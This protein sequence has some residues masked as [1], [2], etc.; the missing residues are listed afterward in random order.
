[1]SRARRSDGDVTK[2]KILEAAGQLIAQNGFAQ[3]SNKAIAQAAKVDLAAI[4]YHF[5]GRDG[6]YKAV[7][8]EAHS[9]YIDEQYLINLVESILPPEEKLENF[10]GTFIE[11]IKYKNQWHSKVFIREIV[12]SSPHLYNFMQ[13]DGNR[14]FRL[15]CKIISQVSG[16]DE[17]NPAL[18]P[19]ILSIVAPCLMLI[20]VGTNVSSP[21][22]SITD[23][24]KSQLV[25]HLTKF[26]LGG[27]QSIKL[28]KTHFVES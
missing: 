13:N 26:A 1:M 5:D 4:N 14:K 16:L 3:T 20:I 17:N 2:S 24:D 18:L 9:H 21:I 12:S 15:V 23:M 11:K 7:L 8:I 19:C 27:L 28:P 25:K 6:L 22:Q 10:I